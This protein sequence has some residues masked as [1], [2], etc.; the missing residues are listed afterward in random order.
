VSGTIS[1]RARLFW[2]GAL[3]DLIIAALCGLVTYLV[4]R[5][6]GRP[7]DGLL[8]LS[9]VDEGALPIIQ[10]ALRT[11]ADMASL[12]STLYHSTAEPDLVDETVFPLLRVQSDGEF[13]LARLMQFRERVAGRSD[14]E[15]ADLAA[16]AAAQAAP[17]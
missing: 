14:T 10:L 7:I 17:H 8:A 6:L 2:S 11:F 16:Q 3:L 5:R 13:A 12:S 9:E 15:W 4:L 1:A